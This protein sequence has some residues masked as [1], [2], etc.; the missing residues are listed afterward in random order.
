[1]I[2]M[3]S[4]NLDSIVGRRCRLLKPVRDHE[5]FS[6]FSERPRILRSVDNLGRRMLLV[7]FDDGATTFLFPDEVVVE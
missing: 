1:M 7:Q 3:E 4:T 6:R 5:G 2:D